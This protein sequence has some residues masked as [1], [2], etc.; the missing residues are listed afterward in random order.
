MV[1]FLLSI[2]ALIVGYFIYGK[3]V[4]KVSEPMKTDQHQRSLK[5]MVLTLWKWTGSEYS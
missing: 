2:V 3:F 4:E 5:M 1:S